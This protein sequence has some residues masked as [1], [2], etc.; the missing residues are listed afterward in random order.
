MTR[1]TNTTHQKHIVRL[2]PCVVTHF[3]SRLRVHSVTAH[4][5]RKRGFHHS[6]VGDVG[7]DDDGMVDACVTRSGVKLR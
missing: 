7:D 5:Q 4:T 1:H 6:D 3:G 2:C